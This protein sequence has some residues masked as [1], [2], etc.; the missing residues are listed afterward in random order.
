[1]IAALQPRFTI[2]HTLTTLPSPVVT[3]AWH[4]TSSR[5]KY[6]V[7]ATQTNDGYIRVWKITKF[8][9]ISGP[10]K[11]KRDSDGVKIFE[12][13]QIGFDG[14]QTGVLSIFPKGE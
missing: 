14:Q 10:A 8:L 3:L 5:Q 13:V 12:N 2:L 7:L 1:M 9:D 11:M 4:T 6:D